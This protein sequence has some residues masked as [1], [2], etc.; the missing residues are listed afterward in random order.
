MDTAATRRLAT[1]TPAAE[2]ATTNEGRRDS[3]SQSC[4]HDGR[5]YREHLAVGHTLS[6]SRPFR[7]STSVPNLEK[8]AAS[9]CHSTTNP[10]NLNST[11]HGARVG[12]ERA[13]IHDDEAEMFGSESLFEYLDLVAAP[14]DG[15]ADELG[16]EIQI[17][18]QAWWVALSHNL[19]LP[20]FVFFLICFG[21][22]QQTLSDTFWNTGARL[23]NV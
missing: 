20:C 5:F 13:G 1:P 19:Y 14:D 22:R 23:S 6:R 9:P 8:T 18:E 7:R 4:A 17:I 12:A 15:S 3:L 11:S 21:S 2:E 16:A 10:T